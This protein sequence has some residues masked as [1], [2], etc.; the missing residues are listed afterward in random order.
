[1]IGNVPPDTPKFL[2]FGWLLYFAIL[3][4]YAVKSGQTSWTF[5]YVVWWVMGTGEEERELARWIARGLVGVF[6]VWFIQHI[7]T[8]GNIF[9]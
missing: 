4:T 8:G 6:C 3:E 7:Y 2:W 5:S 1:M 9:K